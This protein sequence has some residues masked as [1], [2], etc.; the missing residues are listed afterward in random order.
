M[1]FDEYIIHSVLPEIQVSSLYFKPNIPPEKLANAIRSYATDVGMSTVCVLLDESF[2]GNGKEGMLITNDKIILSKKSGDRTFFLS[3]VNQVD[4]IEKNLIVNDAPVTKFRKPEL[5]PL[6]CFGSILNNFICYTQKATV[7][8]QTPLIDDF[9]KSKLID[10]LSTITVP[11]YFES[12]PEDKRNL[13]AKTFNYVLASDITEE[14]DKLI[15]FKGGLLRNEEIICVSWLNRHSCK[16]E[17]FCVT[18][19]GVYSVQDSKTAVFIS[20]EEL[21]ILSADYEYKEDRHIGIRLSDGEGI[22]VSIQNTFVRPYAKELFSGLINILNNR[23][24]EQRF[25]DHSSDEQINNSALSSNVSHLQSSNEITVQ[26]QAVV[27]ND[28]GYPEQ[29]LNSLIFVKHER[30]IL[31]ELERQRMPKKQ[32]IFTCKILDLSKSI[33][34]DFHKS[35]HFDKKLVRVINDDLVILTAFNWC[36]YAIRNILVI[37][38]VNENKIENIL[39]PLTLIISSYHIINNAETYNSLAGKANPQKILKESK[40]YKNFLSIGYYYNPSYEQEGEN[41][42]DDYLDHFFTDFTLV[43]GEK[44]QMLNKYLS[45]NEGC[46][47]YGLLEKYC[48]EYG[49]KSHL[50]CEEFLLELFS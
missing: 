8:T 50:R 38:E 16:N 31:I 44:H 9:V 42:S 23:Q 49:I 4:I 27:V 3:S 19:R 2:L 28:F 15:R 5:M 32:L 6:R 11:L 22:I 41:I 12:C 14:Q 24:S 39:K 47:G 30:E 40:E 25:T 21:K 29:D 1:N 46:D 36:F 34:F 48:F 20:H 18:N 7:V 26:E 45:K 35:K 10:F 17:F 43:L 37:H 13:D 33:V